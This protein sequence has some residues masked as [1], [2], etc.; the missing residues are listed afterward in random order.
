MAGGI[1]TMDQLVTRCMGDLQTGWDG[2]MGSFTAPYGPVCVFYYGERSCAF[3]DDVLRGLRE[4]WGG[5]ARHVCMLGVE[6]A[7]SLHRAVSSG[8]LDEP[9]F[10]TWHDD[11][12]DAYAALGGAGSVRDDERLSVRGMQQAVMAM[13]SAGGVFAKTVQ[14]EVYCVMDSTGMQDAEVRDW[15]MAVND[16]RRALHG[17][18]VNTMLM[19]LLNDAIGTSNAESVTARLRQLYE[20]PDIELPNHHLYD[21]VFVYGNHTVTSFTDLFGGFDVQ[22]HNERDILADVIALTDSDNDYRSVV[23]KSL[24]SPSNAAVTAAFRYC[25]K[26]NRDIVHVVLNHTMQMLAGMLHA[27]VTIDDDT[28][29]RALAIDGS[30]SAIV[31][32]YEPIID[33]IMQRNDGFEQYLPML[34]AGVDIR[35]LSF[36]QADQLTCGCLSAFVEHNHMRQLHERMRDGAGDVAGGLEQRIRGRIADV[37][38][39]DQLLSVGQAQWEAR[40]NAAFGNVILT[41]QSVRRYTV[42][43]AIRQ[44]LVGYVAASVRDVTILVLAGMRDEAGATLNAFKAVLKGITF[45]SA[46][47]QD[48]IHANLDR[49]YTEVTGSFFM[50]PR[51]RIEVMRGMLRIGNTRQDMFEVL[52]AQ[53]WRPL[54][55]ADYGGNRVFRLGFMDELV[56]RGTAGKNPDEAAQ[57]VGKELTDDVGDSVGFHTLRPMPQR[58][59]ETYLLHLDASF[60]TASGKL[61]AYLNNYAKIPGVSRAFF[62]TVSLNSATAIWFYPLTADFL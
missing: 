61:C 56:Q 38:T 28:M 15:Y 1:E 4:A 5:H 51:H 17:V 34:S 45:A 50:N 39:A 9:M 10:V 20:D 59:M 37:L 53:A 31:N 18:S 23:R 19:L 3:H 47:K 42:R 41:E 2:D 30:R 36:D 48:G 32:A 27:D 29:N 62:D 25:D 22:Q 55:D 57:W 16:I 7:A 24:Y 49:F 54:F 43:D 40:I 6:D 60:A 13:M 44:M 35:S 8:L 12:A 58:M 52:Y 26:P 46:V 21:S 14:C 11:T 33:E